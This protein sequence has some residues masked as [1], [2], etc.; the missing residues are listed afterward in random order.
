MVGSPAWPKDSRARALLGA[1]IAGLVVGTATHV[2]NIARAGLIPR[3]ELPLACNVFWSALVIVDPIVALVLLCRPRTG[4]H[5]VAALMA[6][7]L[8]VN[9]AIA[10]LGLS[11]P[12][13][14]QMAYAALALVSVPVVR[15]AR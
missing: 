6:V 7:D 4:V 11:A 15:S 10:R 1:L 13:V 3:P 14:A 2:E 12:I 9:L 5:L 8:T